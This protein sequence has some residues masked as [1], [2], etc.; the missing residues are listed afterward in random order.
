MTIDVC[1]GREDAEGTVDQVERAQSLFVMFLF[2]P[3][4][5]AI[6]GCAQVL[7]IEELARCDETSSCIGEHPALD[8]P[9]QGGDTTQIE[10]V[11]G[12]PCAQENVI[13]CVGA[14]E[15]ERLSCKGGTWMVATSCP[16]GQNCDRQTGECQSIAESCALLAPKDKFCGKGDVLLACNEDL[17]AE[18]TI[19]KCE[20]KCTTVGGVAGCREPV[21]GDGKVE[22]GETCDDANAITEVCPYGQTSCVVCDH[23]CQERPGLTSY[24]GDGAIDAAKETCDDENAETEVCPYGESEC[25][26][27]D[28]SCKEQSGEVAYCGDGKLQAR[29]E[30]DGAM[31]ADHLCSRACERTTWALW[32][33]PPDSLPASNYQVT[34]YTVIDSITKLIWQRSIGSNHYNWAQAKEYCEKLQTGG[35]SDWRLPSRIELVSIRDYVLPTGPQI[36]TNVFSATP[37]ERFWTSSIF[38][39][40]EEGAWTVDFKWAGFTTGAAT[41]SEYLVRCVR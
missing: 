39:G 40:F 10:V 35:F 21:C 30:C 26:V 6:S 5:A 1:S 19:A 11:E 34:T 24:C 36:N 37:P 15:A 13:S 22:T 14:A 25:I 16:D 33:V 31:G 9:G 38:A 18:V 32:S 20:G 28:E 2:L 27:C 29:E 4:T 7:S 17:I 23:V 41:S 12:G 3:A 8:N